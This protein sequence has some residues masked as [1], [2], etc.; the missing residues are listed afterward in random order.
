[1]KKDDVQPGGRHELLDRKQTERQDSRH[2]NQRDAQPMVFKE[3]NPQDQSAEYGEAF[4]LAM[5][6]VQTDKPDGRQR[7]YRCGHKQSEEDR[8]GY[9]AFPQQHQ[10]Q[11]SQHV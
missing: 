7:R 11:G 10:A 1:M 5:I 4:D 6:Q 3:K 9:A 2:S 8:P